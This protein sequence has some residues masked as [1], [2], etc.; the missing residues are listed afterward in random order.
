MA[1]TVEERI[2]IAEKEL[3]ELQ[4]KL[5]SAGEFY[6]WPNFQKDF[7]MTSIGIA[8]G[9]KRT[10][11][12]YFYWAIAILIFIWAIRSKRIRKMFKK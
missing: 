12:K 3:Y 8:N 6:A 5:G 1:L 11:K 7:S 4:Q 2:R 9:E 10:N